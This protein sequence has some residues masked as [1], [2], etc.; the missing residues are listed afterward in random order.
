MAFSIQDYRK[1]NYEN[2]HDAPI[3]QLVTL[4]IEVIKH[5]PSKFRRQPYRVSCS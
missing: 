4:K 1:K 2:I 5:Y 3:N